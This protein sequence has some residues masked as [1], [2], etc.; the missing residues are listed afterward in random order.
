MV[1]ESNQNVFLVQI[2]ASSFA[3]FEIS[4]LERSRFHCTLVPSFL[5]ILESVLPHLTVGDGRDLPAYGQVVGMNLHH[6]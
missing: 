3:E 4:E 5:A 2:H 1:G 6:L